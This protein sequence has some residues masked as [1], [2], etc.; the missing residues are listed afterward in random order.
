[1]V[2][3]KRVRKKPAKLRSS[4]APSPN[5]A[6]PTVEA[7]ETEN[8]GTGPIGAMTRWARLNRRLS[9][10]L[11]LPQIPP[12]ESD[13][14]RII[15]RAALHSRKSSIG[16][17]RANLSNYDAAEQGR[18]KKTPFTLAELPTYKLQ[19]IQRRIGGRLNP[20]LLSGALTA[21]IHGVP[22][23]LSTD[24]L[25]A[26][27]EHLSC[28]RFTFKN[29]GDSQAERLHEMVRGSLPK[30]IDSYTLAEKPLLSLL[31]LAKE[32]ARPTTLQNKLRRTLEV[33]RRWFEKNVTRNMK[34]LKDAGEGDEV[35][36]LAIDILPLII[37]RL[38]KEHARPLAEALST[39]LGAMTLGLL[40]CFPL[41]K[42]DKARPQ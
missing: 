5:S 39:P 22:L 23:C 34:M 17:T 16:L 20:G 11:T 38:T 24:E 31:D 33:R 1:M 3:N 4:R 15:R 40:P 25:V 36:M 18:L 41:P 26:D 30:L 10:V 9:F 28:A 14:K 29:P 8:I 21:F 19:E 7:A 32:N 35:A 42:D 27:A 2:K 12:E 6:N 37:T 13:L